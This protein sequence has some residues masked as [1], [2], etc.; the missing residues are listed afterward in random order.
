M[1]KDQR[2]EAVTG[3]SLRGSQC[4]QCGALL[5]A[6]AGAEGEQLKIRIKVKSK[7]LAYVYVHLTMLEKNQA[8][9]MIIRIKINLLENVMLNPIDGIR[10][11]LSLFLISCHLGT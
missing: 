3:G 8:S 6:D 1:A 9:V 7:K 11:K 4:N 5:S 2:W 10:N